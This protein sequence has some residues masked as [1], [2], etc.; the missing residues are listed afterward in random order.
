MGCDRVARRDRGA[1]P[2]PTGF[3]PRS[4]RRRVAACLL[5]LLGFAVASSPPPAA[6]QGESE[7]SVDLMVQ[8]LVTDLKQGSTVV[9]RPFS[10]AHTGLPDLIADRIETLV[11]SA[12][13]TR[14]PRDMEVTLVTGNDV[15]E[16][17]ESLEES[18]F[19]GDQERLLESVLRSAR[20]DAVLACMP[21]GVGDG[22]SHFEIRCRATFARLVCPGG[23]DVESCP[24]VEVE[25]IGNQGGGTARVPYRSRHEYLDHVFSDLAWKLAR[26]AA[27]DGKE[28][29]EVVPES[30]DSKR[31][32]ALETFVSRK[33]R[34]KIRQAGR[35]RLGPRTIGDDRVRPMRLAWSV[36]SFDEMYSLSVTMDGGDVP[37]DRNVWVAVSAIPEDMRLSTPKV[38]VGGGTGAG[39]DPGERE[40]HPN[41]PLGGQAILVVETEPSG[42]SVVVGGEGVGETPLTRVDLR[43]GTWSVVVDHPWYETIRLE[44]QVLEEFVVLRIERRLIR[45]SGRATVLLEAPVSGAWVDHGGNRREVPVSLDGLPVG[46]VILTLG[47]PGH[48]DLRVEVE[49]PKEGLEWP[50]TGHCMRSRLTGDGRRGQ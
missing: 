32:A 43:A 42:A 9:V 28:A 17:Y 34:E 7:R 4:A 37:I 14:I 18:A 10:S 6:A 27:L 19:G 30:D 41:S 24:N 8:E 45:A 2:G 1:G 48:H 50:R 21:F 38:V 36:F 25:D 15:L 39:T 16:I 46:P 23:G 35:E 29:L 40:I 3:V 22:P 11:L 20:A 44:E 13:R 5:A 49:V 26:D 33:L 31:N 12:L 47:A